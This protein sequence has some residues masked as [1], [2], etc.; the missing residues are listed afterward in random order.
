MSIKATWRERLRYRVDNFLA[1]GS[2]ALFLSL[3]IAFL[4]AFVFFVL[5]R[6]VIVLLT[7]EAKPE[8]VAQVQPEQKPEGEAPPN[9]DKKPD[10]DA[11]PNPEEKP[12]F[13]RDIWR[14]FLQVSDPGAMTEDNDSPV[15]M[16]LAAVAAAFTG[17][18]I[19]SALVA[20]LTT[21]LTQAID[22]LKQ[23]HSRVLESG[24]TLIL[25]WGPRVSEI[26]RE[27]AEANE[28]EKN[29]CVTI[30]SD[31]SKETMDTQLG[32][33]FKE[34]KNTR[35]VTRS[36][37]IASL[38]SLDRVSASTAKSAIVLATCGP[39]ATEDEKQASDAQVIK[40]VL[41]LDLK[42]GKRE[43]FNIVAEI[44]TPRNRHVVMDITPGRVVV[45]N[46][47][48]ILAKIMVQ[49]S[50]TSGLS[51]VYS[52]LLSFI[53][54][55][56]YFHHAKWDG[57]TFGAMQYHFPD[58]VPIGLRKA[59]GTLH[60][61][62]EPD[63]E[64]DDDDEILI[65]AQD[66]STIDFRQKP[67]IKPKNL[68]LAKTVAERQKE[69]MLILG[70]SPKA[71][72]ITSEYADYVLE[73]SQVDV[74]ISGPSEER[75]A[76]IAE[77]WAGLDTVQVTLIDKN[78]LDSNELESLNP[79]DYNNIV[80]LPQRPDDQMDAERTDAETIVLLLHLRGLQRKFEEQGL[81]TN[82]KILTE[83]LD[84]NNQDLICKA[85]VN[86]FLISSRMVSMIFAQLSEEPRMIEVYDN[87]FE[88]EGSEIYV[89]SASLYFAEL[90]VSCT[91]AD[92][93]ALAQKRNGEVCIGY[94]LKSL[95]QDGSANFGVSIIP[96]KDTIVEITEED[97][98]VVV[99]EDDQ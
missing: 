95:E 86:D 21:A 39:A 18:I 91:Y 77:L 6:G 55:E 29:P 68:P 96:P 7:P 73:G 15:V 12:G 27:L 67:V 47:E 49:T 35:I 60:I 93:M 24:H 79:F 20:F 94:K 28:S 37:P 81:T 42:V 14:A 59:D 90:P 88:E 82:T 8:P 16:K 99:A 53:G 63:T 25:G 84:S 74:V 31:V 72:I 43:D 78:P 17:V 11:K 65:I 58:G 62:P 97:A 61:R 30:L 45:V 48:E 3:V 5:V 13:G 64:L 33:Q 71:P 10:A 2:G 57:I 34:R 56:M 83:V 36:G 46:T 70:W 40:A 44:F 87:L 32:L 22:R 75:R 92:L 85:G 23:G 98:L 66:D 26:L 1:K 54:S 51:V 52:E 89:K 69:R 50:R 80:I 19:F 41:A 9:P 76:E 38:E 4:L